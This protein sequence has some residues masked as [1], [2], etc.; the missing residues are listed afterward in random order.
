MSD[1]L[2]KVGATISNWL[3][4]VGDASE[5]VGQRGLIVLSVLA[6]IYGLWSSV[7]FR[8][9][10]V[11]GYGDYN[12]IVATLMTFAAPF[13]CLGYGIWLY[14]QSKRESN[15]QFN[16]SLRVSYRL[17]DRFQLM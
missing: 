16:I 1:W 4:K 7:P 9:F 5:F 2:A 14:L 17:L 15:D 10:E 6:W 3:E 13:L 11:I 12:F 8:G